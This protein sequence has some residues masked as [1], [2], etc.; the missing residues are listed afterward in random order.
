V[1]QGFSPLD[2]ELGLLSGSLSPQAQEWLVRLGAWMPFKQAAQ[3]LGALTGIQVS[4]ATVRRQTEAAGAAYE[5]VQTAEVA[6]IKQ[7]LPDA[8]QGAAQQMVSADGAFVPLVHGEWGEVKTL[9]LGEVHRSRRGEPCTRHLSYFSRL[10][11]VATFEELALVETHRRGLEQAQAV[12]AVLDGAEWLQGLVDYHRPDAVRIL[13]FAH[14]AE[15]ISAIGQAVSDAGTDLGA[16]WLSER[17]HQLKHDGPLSVLAE[18]RVLR[19]GHPQ[20]EEVSE[21]LAYLE[22]RVDQMQYPSYQADGWPIG[23]GSVESAHKV[24]MQARL[25]GAGMH[26]Q[27]ANVNPMLALRTAVCNDRWTEAW[28]AL[29]GHQQRQRVQRRQ[30]RAQALLMSVLA[31]MAVLFACFKP[32]IRSPELAAS[33]CPASPVQAFEREEGRPNR[34]PAANHPWRRSLITRRHINRCSVPAKM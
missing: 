19:E 13:D 6:E 21:R 25:K 23:S 33:R 12:C 9:A 26:W 24:V 30:D 14:A 29:S 31:Q 18:L 17:L 8:P 10:A 15:Y 20:V 7:A 2:E 5:A 32:A 34:S 1:G 28:G 4:Q 11:E 16:S 22:K 3:M 27:R